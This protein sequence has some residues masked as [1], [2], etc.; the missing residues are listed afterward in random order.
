VALSN[1]KFEYVGGDYVKGYTNEVTY[2]MRIKPGSYVIRLKVEKL[3]PEYRVLLNVTSS[4]ET[5][6]SE[7]KS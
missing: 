4:S 2:H 5:M 3:L 6:I 7:N 1:H